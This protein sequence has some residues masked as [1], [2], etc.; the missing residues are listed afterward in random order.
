MKPPNPERLVVIDGTPITVHSAGVSARRDRELVS[1][2]VFAR[3]RDLRFEKLT[4]PRLVVTREDTQ[5]A[6]SDELF[7][8]E[9]EDRVV[10]VQELGVEDDLDA[11]RVSVEELNA[12]NLVQ[13]GVVRVIGH[14]VRHDGRERV[15]TEREDATLEEDL[16]LGGEE[17]GGVGNL[18]TVLT[19]HVSPSIS[20]YFLV[21]VRETGKLTQCI[22]QSSRKASLRYGFGSR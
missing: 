9:T 11:V 22:E 8:V 10:R 2:E 19:G 1:Y 7:V 6:S 17:L 18:G 4:T 3:V 15:A 21:N 13:D 20:A 14:V 12:A 16:V 5:V